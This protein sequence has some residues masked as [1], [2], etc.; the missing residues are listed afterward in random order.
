MTEG[1]EIRAAVA[2]LRDDRN[3]NNRHLNSPSRELLAMTAV[4]LRAREPL[5][6]LLEH[7]ARAYDS[8]VTAAQRVWPDDE[9][10]R[11]AFVHEGESHRM[12][13]AVARAINGPARPGH[14]QP[15]PITD[16]LD[17]RSLLRELT[18]EDQT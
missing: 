1:D 13:I 10:K 9:P 15:G 16:R 4:L 14:A 7:A 17:P 12:A 2:V 3:C 6:E 8:A 11:N 5:A 18:T